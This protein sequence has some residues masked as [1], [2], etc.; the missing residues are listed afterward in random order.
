[1][2]FKDLEQQISLRIAAHQAELKRIADR[3]AYKALRTANNKAKAARPPMFRP[4]PP[5]N[6]RKVVV[7]NVRRLADG[8]HG[9]LLTV[10][11]TVDTVAAETMARTLA[12][13]DGYVWRGTVDIQ[14]A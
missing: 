11:Y 9:D 7:M 12:E 8:M 13:A 10:Q 3:K 1:M 5:P 2:S 6:Y 14:G 4:D